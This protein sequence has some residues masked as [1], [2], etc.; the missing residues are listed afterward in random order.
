MNNPCECLC[1]TSPRCRTKSQ[2]TFD[3]ENCTTLACSVHFPD[4]CPLYPHP[5]KTRATSDDGPSQTYDSTYN[6]I[7]D[8][9]VAAIFFQIIGIVGG[10]VI[11]IY[12]IV[13]I[14]Y[15]I[16]TK[17]WT[18]PRRNWAWGI[19][20]LLLVAY[21]AVL[22]V[23]WLRARSPSEKELTKKSDQTQSP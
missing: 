4:A 6:A 12:G 16:N 1:C 18:S 10:I 11:F 21:I 2:G 9:V 8:A 17:T 23:L 15:R 13:L 22:S 20:A 19:L 3:T 14:G 5:G 7:N